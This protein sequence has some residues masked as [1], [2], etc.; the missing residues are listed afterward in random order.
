MNGM[1][2]LIPP[3]SGLLMSAYPVN[4]VTVRCNVDAN[5]DTPEGRSEKGI[6]AESDTSICS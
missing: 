5:G 2:A 3:K 1:R 6:G 4:A